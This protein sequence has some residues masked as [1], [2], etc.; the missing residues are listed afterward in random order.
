VID[1]HGLKIQWE[2]ILGLQTFLGEGTPFSIF[3]AFLTRFGKI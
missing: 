2:G 3:I 1:A